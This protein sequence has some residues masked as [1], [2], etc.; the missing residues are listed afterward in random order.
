M[1]TRKGLDWTQKFQKIA[2]AAR[3]LPNCILDGEVVA[4]DKDGA[5]NFATLQGAI[6]EDKT[7]GLV[8]FAFDLLFEGTKDLRDL[9]LSKRKTR[10]EKLLTG[11]RK[12][13]KVIRFVEHFETSGDAVCVQPA[14]CHWKALFQSR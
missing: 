7:D 13:T 6:S 1:R 5:P 4:L 3:V 9:P 2:S 11:H 12:L 10:L 14:G 8:F